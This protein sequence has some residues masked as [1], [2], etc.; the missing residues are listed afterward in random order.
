MFGTDVAFTSRL[1]AGVRALDVSNPASPKEVGS[2]V[3]PAVADPSAAAGAG[4]SNLDIGD[5]NNLLRGA[6]W[7]NRPLATG[8]GVIPIDAK[9]AKVVASDINGG[10]YVLLA[11]VDP[12]PPIPAVVGVGPG[13]APPRREAV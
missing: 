9:N 4:I 3:P 13:Q 12:P 8:V 5:P 2:F 7:P 11:Q 6:S 1:S 10:L